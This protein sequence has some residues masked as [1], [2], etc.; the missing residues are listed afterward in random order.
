MA[1]GADAQNVAR[2]STMGR[3]SLTIGAT[4]VLMYHLAR[5]ARITTLR[6]NNS[7]FLLLPDVGPKRPA[8]V[9]HQN[10]TT[11]VVLIGSPFREFKL[12]CLPVFGQYVALASVLA[13]M[14]ARGLC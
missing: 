3:F 10:G 4:V 11:P 1:A 8:L 2:P 12:K 6:F 14:A 9:V 7:V 5:D 13:I